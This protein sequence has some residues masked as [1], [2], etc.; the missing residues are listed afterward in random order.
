MAFDKLP[1]LKRA[2]A[3]A[4]EKLNVLKREY[5]TIVKR[6]ED[7][8]K[9]EDADRS[10]LDQLTDSIA[11]HEQTIRDHDDRIT[12]CERALQFEADAST[13]VDQSDAGRGRNPDR[14]RQRAE[15]RVRKT[16]YETDPSLVIGGC[17]RML[18][19]GGGTLM[20]ARSMAIEILGERNPVTEV[21]HGTRGFDGMSSDYQRSLMASIGASGG[22]IVPPDYVAELIEVLRPMAVVRSSGPRTIEMPRGTMQ[23]PRQNQ[24]ATATYGGETTAIPVSQQT[25][26]QIV[27]TYKK[28]TAL[29][30]VSNDL[31]RYSDPAVDALVRDDLAQ[32][33]Q[34]REDL[35]F[36]RGDG[37]QDSPK[38]FLTFCL[39]GQKITSNSSYTLTTAAQELGGALNKVES[40][41]VPMENLVWMM[42]PRSKNYLLNVQNSNGFYVYREEMTEPKTLLGWPF[43][44]TTQIPINL[45]VGANS[46]CSEIYLVAMKQ[47]MLFDSM[48]LELAVSREGTYTD[49][50]ANLVSVF[51]SDQTMI[52]A[53]AEHDFHMR[54]DEAISII[55]GVRWAPAIS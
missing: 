7:G 49:A 9:T 14:V 25:V 5:V 37:T 28:L 53:I 20:G 6:A 30:P 12:R 11:E 10:R 44:T 32:V 26:G 4:V 39:P 40:A 15:A 46:D 34:R 22:F 54:H 27:A 45:T 18:A 3:E 17:C 23:M 21:L 42:N 13:P 55:T 31:M 8:E 38:G 29:T 47:A 36:I 16:D 41:N 51:Q 52:R 24:A 33:I 19:A 35:A 2:R 50:N 1:D 48:R 43:K